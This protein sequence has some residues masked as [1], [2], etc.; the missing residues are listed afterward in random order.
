[1]ISRSVMSCQ[2]FTL[3]KACASVN[4]RVGE[5]KRQSSVKKQYKKITFSL[6]YADV[7]RPSGML[8][9]YVRMSVCDIKVTRV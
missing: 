9:C 1:M 5:Q 6:F 3:F 7:C 8:I 4:T 2:P